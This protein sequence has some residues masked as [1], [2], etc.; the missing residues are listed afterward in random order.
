MHIS[1][2]EEIGKISKV[3]EAK[4]ADEDKLKEFM[5]IDSKRVAELRV[6]LQTDLVRRSELMIK[7]EDS[8]NVYQETRTELRTVMSKLQ[9]IKAAKEWELAQLDSTLKAIAQKDEELQRIATEYSSVMSRNSEKANEVLNLRNKLESAQK[10]NLK[11]ISQN[12]AVQR[13][14]AKLAT[15]LRRA[16]M[17]EDEAESRLQAQ[18]NELVQITGSDRR[19]LDLE[20]DEAILAVE[21][22]VA[23]LAASQ[24]VLRT[25]TGKLKKLEAGQIS[26]HAQLDEAKQLLENTS[27][28]VSVTEEDLTKTKNSLFGANLR[29][30][31]AQEIAKTYQA[32]LISQRTRASQ[33]P[34]EL[35]KLEYEKNRLDQEIFS[36]DY[37][38]QAL[39]NAKSSPVVAKENKAELMEELAAS[40]KRLS[41][42]KS[43]LSGLSNQLA[44]K[45]SEYAANQ[46]QYAK[47][48]YVL[49]S[50]TKKL[51]DIETE[52]E[53]IDRT[54]TALIHEKGSALVARDCGV[55]ELNNGKEVLRV[56]VAKFLEESKRREEKEFEW[57]QE[58]ANI[59][60]QAIQ[61]RTV[62]KELEAHRHVLAVRVGQA[63][64]KNALLTIERDSLIRTRVGSGEDDVHSQAYQV[65]K[66]AQDREQLVVTEAELV[67]AVA[68]AASELAALETAEKQVNRSNSSFIERQRTALAPV[69][70]VESEL[71]QL[72][73]EQQLHTEEEEDDEKTSGEMSC[74]E[75]IET[76]GLVDFKKSIRKL[77]TTC[78]EIFC[79]LRQNLLLKG[80]DL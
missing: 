56:T 78:P 41:E 44:K 53:S 20:L 31:R 62:G 23:A 61:L 75:A 4:H 33:L 52:A 24:E 71:A 34:G 25:E 11:K 9:L 36:L 38:N 8:A 18:R 60:M 28:S 59:N 65:I 68:T 30:S 49:E 7:V 35:R 22:R 37:E 67:A 16:E 14:L 15:E 54:E 58:A 43:V 13:Q 45:N 21:A 6:V 76:I 77:A 46:R 74:V 66:A 80:I 17:E 40:E 27:E 64:Q 72:Q 47:Y 26:L 2:R 42:S 5:K 29:L 1:F 79:V 12:E 55:A 50:V 32:N 51:H 69:V 48:Q 57:A 63:S 39:V 70:Y 19:K 3:S 10:S 73:A